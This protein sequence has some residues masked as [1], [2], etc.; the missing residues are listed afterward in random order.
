MEYTNEYV[1]W[2][3]LTDRYFLNSYSLAGKKHG[4]TPRGYVLG[5]QGV[6]FWPRRCKA[7]KGSACYFHDARCQMHMTSRIN[8]GRLRV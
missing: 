6:R 1:N 8:G 3:I 5:F 2:K 4:R 7:K